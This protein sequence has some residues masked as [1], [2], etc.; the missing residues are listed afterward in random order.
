MPRPNETFISPFQNPKIMDRS[1]GYLGGLAEFYD[2]FYASKPY[3]EEARF[4]RDRLVQAGVSPTGRLL[5]IACGTGRHAVEFA[6]LGFVVMATDYAPP[7]LER[8]RTR[9]RGSGLPVTICRQDMRTLCIDGPPFEAAVCLFDSIGYVETNEALLD[10]FAGI[11]R[12]LHPGGAFLFEFLHAPAMLRK[13]EPVRVRRWQGE[14]GAL[15]IRISETELDMETQVASVTQ[16][17]L[18]SVP[19]AELREV[20]ETLRVRLFSVP[21]VKLL[22]TAS[23][24]SCC[25]YWSGF[26]SEGRVTDDTWHVVMAAIPV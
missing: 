15:I 26:S 9:L 10:T 21:E 4:I 14:E 5:E 17:V 6:R 22:L 11:R 1:Q 25:G 23:G 8:A 20:V 2:V 19:G 12:H 7:M 16:R 3:V 18:H 24:W 13:Y